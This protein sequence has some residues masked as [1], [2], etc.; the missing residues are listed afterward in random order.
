MLT[1]LVSLERH[2]RRCASLRCPAGLAQ[3][4]AA[5]S[6]S[7]A[8]AQGPRH[9][10]NR[11][12]SSSSS[13]SLRG[14]AAWP[15]P[16]GGWGATAAC[17]S[18][19][20]TRGSTL[21]ARALLS[22]AGMKE[23]DERAG[24]EAAA[25][26]A[27]AS[28][29]GRGRK[30]QAGAAGEG[31]AAAGK[32]SPAKG[33]GKK[34]AAAA[35]AAAAEEDLESEGA[36]ASREGSEAEEEEE[37]APKRAPKRA[38]TS[39]KTKVEKPGGEG[40]EDKPKPA[41][42]SRAKPAAKEG[43]TDAAGAEAKPKAKRGGKTQQPAANLVHY[44]A[45]MRKPPPPAAAAGS[46]GGGG[47][48]PLNILSW[49]VAGLRALLKKTPDAVSSLV[50]RE[51]AQV[52]CLQEHKLQA[53]NQ[54]EVEGLLGLKGWHHAWAFS[55][56]KL[57]YSGVSVHTAQPPLSVVVGLGHGGAGAPDPDPEHEG[58][59]R[60]VT[61]ELEG[62]FV[63]NVYVPNSGEGLKRL[64]YRVG[65]WDG[66]FAAFLRGLQAR[67]KPVV[68]T[69]DLNC[70]HKEI[71]IHAPK[72]NLKSAGF[73]PE[74]RESFGRLLLGEAGLADTFRRLYPDTVAYTYFTRRFNCRE[75]NKGWRLDYFLTSESMM[76]PEA[77][78]GS[79]AAQEEAAGAAKAEPASAWTVYDTWIMQD[80]YGSDHLPLGLTCV[81]KAAA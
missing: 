55:T 8:G 46:G 51:G 9:A 50:A 31:A 5:P 74:E 38:K 4:A 49:N 3:T 6:I 35:A 39:A 62:V 68:V 54:Q 44:T 42:K 73:T 17:A 70:A 43:D 77:Q 7:Q 37:A 75:K 71:D 36:A 80:V 65:R 45:A 15:T 11:G 29:K 78:E 1:K 57:G 24:E 52:V 32:K 40:E 41:R 53:G 59:G 2:C 30:A 60:V 64:D 33:R 26:P 67:G 22:S 48:P 16:S 12:S 34:A 63:V 13:S 56:A 23:D 10:H 81:K 14:S 69:G 28:P 61:V 27:A 19:L 20:H 66:A 25:E 21:A 58:E 79:T 72:T 76:P 47:S 18:R